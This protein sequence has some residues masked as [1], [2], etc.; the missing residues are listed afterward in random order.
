MVAEKAM[1][2]AVNRRRFDVD[3][4]HRMDETGILRPDER[5]E[6]IDGEI[7]AKMSIG[8]RH[9]AS[10]N[11]ATRALIGLVGETAIVQI[12]GS[13]RLSR[14]TEPEPDVALLR[15]RADFYASHIAEPPDILLVIEAADSSLRFDRKV[16]A[17]VY[18]EAKVPEYWLVDV[19]GCCVFRYTGARAGSYRV[20]RKYRSGESIAPKALPECVVPV[21]TLLP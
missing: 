5:V 20:V 21:D 3:E 11:R 18:A 6:L 4:Y 7:L 2:V 9:N 17:R 14:Y 19:A 1:D 8:P 16:K 15:P 10:L 13:V 12:A